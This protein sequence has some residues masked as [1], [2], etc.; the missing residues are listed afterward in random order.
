M[1]LNKMAGQVSGGNGMTRWERGAYTRRK[2]VGSVG[3]LVTGLALGR[4]ALAQAEQA[5][6]VAS[7]EAGEW[8]Y[9]DVLGK[10]VTLPTRPVRIAATL[11]TAA[12]LWDLGIQVV[13]VFDWTA[14]AHPNGDHIAW[15]SVDPKAVANV[16]DIDGNIKPED[17]LNS[18][19]DLILTLTFDPADP[20]STVGVLP[21]FA[22][23]I[24]QIAPVLVVTDMAST[25]TQLER[26][27]DL[28][29]RL[30]ADL[31]VPEVVEARTAY[32]AKL[33]EF[34]QTVHAAS[35]LTTLFANF[36]ADTYYVAG[37]QGVSE[38]LFLSELGLRFA[39]ADSP[40]AA[41]FWETLSA[42]EALRYPSDIIF[43]D[44]YSAFQGIDA[45][46]SQAVYAA[47]PAIAAGQVGEWNRDFPVN[48]AGVTDFLETILVTLRTA[49]KV[50]G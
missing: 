22:A 33:D 9:T 2:V 25:A 18:R 35:D 40:E 20:A 47:M 7:P 50:T 1:S 44:V 23:T 8:T 6:Q 37:P 12:A 26:L 5:S 48:Y 39:N 30:G 13:A 43:N 19:P 42:E 31:A 3:G 14:S 17:L 49:T 15:G 38:L 21:D 27:V 24:E 4:S 41:S 32:E 28:A 10:T 46:Q 34:Q 45:L 36:D 11:V 29:G 16:G